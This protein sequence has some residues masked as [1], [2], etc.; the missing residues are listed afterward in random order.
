MNENVYGTVLRKVYEEKSDSSWSYKLVDLVFVH[1]FFN[2]KSY[3]QLSDIDER[4]FALE[5]LKSNISEVN[6][7]A[8]FSYICQL[9]DDVLSKLLI[10]LSADQY[11]SE[12]PGFNKRISEVKLLLSVANDF[13]SSHECDAMRKEILEAIQRHESLLGNALQ[14]LQLISAQIDLK[15]IF[16]GSEM[17]AYH[18]LKCELLC[19]VGIM[20]YENAANRNFLIRNNYLNLLMQSVTYDLDN[21]FLREHAIVALKHLHYEEEIKF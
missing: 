14:L 19:S 6:Q 8:D 18:S 21:P 3:S 16:I 11:E 9:L 20:V 17:C 2:L 4:I 12:L 10:Y 7:I 15:K 1:Q 5:L 13:V